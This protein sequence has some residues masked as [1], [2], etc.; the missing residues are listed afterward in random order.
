[1]G[2]FGQRIAI[3]HLIS[4]KPSLIKKVGNYENNKQFLLLVGTEFLRDALRTFFT[5]HISEIE[6]LYKTDEEGAKQKTEI[7]MSEFL[8]THKLSLWYDQSFDGQYLDDLQKY[9]C[10]MAS[11]TLLLMNFIHSIRY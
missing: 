10:D 6:H 9:A 5:N 4:N 8:D 1:M 11:S 3:S 7:L 2:Y